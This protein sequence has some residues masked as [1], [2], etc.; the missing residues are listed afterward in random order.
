MSRRSFYIGRH[1]ETKDFDELYSGFRLTTSKKFDTASIGIKSLDS[2]SENILLDL[3]T[4]GLVTSVEHIA[5]V[6]SDYSEGTVLMDLES[7]IQSLLDIA[8]IPEE[9]TPI[10]HAQWT[11]AGD[12]MEITSSN[13]TVY[14]IKGFEKTCTAQNVEEWTRSF[15]LYRELLHTTY[16]DWKDLNHE[17]DQTVE[18]PIQYVKRNN[19]P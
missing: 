4:R 12:L 14:K 6:Y 16:Q 8:Q 15:S 3:D 11:S 13:K 2:D 7:M 1:V 19:L 5:H 17:F 18:T 10:K 9:E